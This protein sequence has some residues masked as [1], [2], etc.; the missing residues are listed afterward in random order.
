MF[1][2]IGCP[3]DEPCPIQRT[4]SAGL[5]H[6][7]DHRALGNAGAREKLFAFASVEIDIDGVQ[8]GV[9]GIRAMREDKG[10]AIELPKFRDAGGAWRAAI[11]LPEEGHS[12]IA[13]A[14]FDELV[15]L[16]LAVRR[17]G[18]MTAVCPRPG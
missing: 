1:S 8:I 3:R 4:R 9:H 18:A 7:R 11:T 6:R 16:G 13:K 2:P 12:P 5:E 17:L 15:E 14:V 10:T